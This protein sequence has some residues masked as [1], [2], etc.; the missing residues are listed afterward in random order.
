M[1]QIERLQQMREWIKTSPEISLDQLMQEYQISR[2]T[3][4]RDVIV[5]EQEGEIIRV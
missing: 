5:L 1:G 4:R 3:A 2:D